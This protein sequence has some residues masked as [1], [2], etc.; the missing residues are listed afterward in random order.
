MKNGFDDRAVRFQAARDHTHLVKLQ[1]LVINEFKDL[2]RRRGDFVMD[3]ESIDDP[4]LPMF[5][6][7]GIFSPYVIIENTRGGGQDGLGFQLFY[8][9]GI[10]AVNIAFVK[11]LGET[12]GIVARFG[13]ETGKK[14]RGWIVARYGIKKIQ[15]DLRQIIEAVIKNLTELP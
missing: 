11:A 7:G 15:L 3:P 1:F 10:V 4:A 12:P 9:F 5:R 6:Q 8:R 14:K 13:G 2:L